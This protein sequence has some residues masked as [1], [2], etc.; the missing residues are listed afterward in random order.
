MA[1]FLIAALYKFVELSD[2]QQ[3]QQP[4]IEFCE[5]HHVKGTLLLAEEGING[6]IAGPEQAVQ[7]VLAYFREDPRL[8]TLDHQASW[9]DNMPFYRRTVRLKRA[10]VTLGVQHVNAHTKT[11]LM[12]ETG[13]AA[14][15]QT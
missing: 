8:T 12:L 3:L 10:V 9:A 5:A 15:R 6:T 14:G 7:A 1:N 2:Y 11:R 4:L 13:R